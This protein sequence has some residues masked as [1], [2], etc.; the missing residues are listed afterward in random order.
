MPRNRTNTSRRRCRAEEGSQLSEW[1]RPVVSL[2]FRELGFE[3]V[4]IPQH[5][6]FSGR[7]VSCPG[8]RFLGPAALGLDAA[9]MLW[10]A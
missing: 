4:A 1:N 3:I 6:A 2:R 5:F 8:H 9:T 7:R 10:G